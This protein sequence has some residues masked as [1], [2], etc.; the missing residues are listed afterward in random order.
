MK[1]TYIV[2]LLACL[3]VTATG[4]RAEQ[5]KQTAKLESVTI[6]TSG[7][8]VKRTK[9]VALK[10]GEQT[11]T[12]TGFSPYMDTKSLQVRANG[13][14]TVLGVS[15]RRV[16]ADSLAQARKLSQDEQAVASVER[17]IQQVQ[18]AQQVLDAQAE[19]VKS[20]SSE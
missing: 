2:L 9:T 8:Q 7:A 17:K 11:V 18:D 12:F 6:F 3:A 10:A 14:L 5:E 15:H 20:N 4:A 19:Q 1:Q 16:I 13:R